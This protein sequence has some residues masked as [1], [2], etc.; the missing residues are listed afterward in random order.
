M[1][2]RVSKPKLSITESEKP[3]LHKQCSLKSYIRFQIHTWITFFGVINVDLDVTNEVL[4]RYYVII[5]QWTIC[6]KIECCSA[7]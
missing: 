1:R 5:G 2:L 4:C 6:W 3:K 7:V